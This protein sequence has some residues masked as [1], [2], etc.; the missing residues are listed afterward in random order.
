M[1]WRW[2]GWL[3]IGRVWPVGDECGESGLMVLPRETGWIVDW[4]CC[5]SLVFLWSWSGLHVPPGNKSSAL[6]VS[7]DPAT[8]TVFH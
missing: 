2:K 4:V 6:D 5:I 3:T 1:R 7:A 8:R